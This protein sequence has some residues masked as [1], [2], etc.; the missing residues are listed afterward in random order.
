MPVVVDTVLVFVSILYV[1]LNSLIFPKFS[2][3]LIKIQIQINLIMLKLQ[4]NQ[5]DLT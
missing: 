1:K 5:S 2:I 3:V 4:L